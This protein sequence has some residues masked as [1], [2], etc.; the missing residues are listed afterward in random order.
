MQDCRD[1]R[2]NWICWINTWSRITRISRSALIIR[3][4][5][6]DRRIW[7]TRL[8]RLNMIIRNSWLTVTRFGWNSAIHL[9]QTLHQFSHAVWIGLKQSCT[10]LVKAARWLF[11]GHFWPLLNAHETN[12]TCMIS[13]SKPISIIIGD[14]QILI[15]LALKGVASF[16]HGRLLGNKSPICCSWSCFFDFWRRLES[17]IESW[18]SSRRVSGPGSSSP[19][20]N[21]SQLTYKRRKK[22]KIIKKTELGK[23][24][25][26]GSLRQ[27]KC[28]MAVQY[29]YFHGN[30]LSNF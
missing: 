21:C 14:H 29:S 22:K 18:V 2:M 7:I 11:L 19:S 5:R 27:Y 30:L 16:M 13:L 26:W 24:E 23:I 25:L 20:Q 12:I 17:D 8:N 15:I 6:I 9:L 28:I 10:T 1:C 4:R 3:V